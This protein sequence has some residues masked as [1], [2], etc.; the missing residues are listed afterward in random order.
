MPVAAK[1]SSKDD[2]E[3]N[4]RSYSKILAICKSGT[5]DT[6][7]HGRSDKIS[8]VLKDPESFYSAVERIAETDYSKA[9][10]ADL[11]N[12]I[13][14]FRTSL[15]AQGAGGLPG[16]DPRAMSA[17]GTDGEVT[18]HDMMPFQTGRTA[19]DFATPSVYLSDRYQ[20]ASG[21]GLRSHLSS[22]RFYTNSDRFRDIYDQRGI[23]F[24]L[25]MMAVGWGYGLDSHYA[26]PSGTAEEIAMFPS[27]VKVFRGGVTE[28]WQVDPSNYV[29]API[30]F[31]Y[32][33]ERHVWTCGAGAG[34]LP[35]GQYQYMV[36]QMVT[37]N[38]SGWDFVRAHPILEIEEVP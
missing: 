14:P 10:A 12:L 2:T 28:G 32:D 8:V 34:E 37:T 27:G 4:L 29:T 35:K 23:A 33:E 36:Y 38:E 16:F 21:D 15:T 25:P 5:T 22:T 17:S 26:V 30:D 20:A 11:S 18:F 9:A 7:V 31:Q 3:K 6:S 13:F 1:T 24:R 19:N